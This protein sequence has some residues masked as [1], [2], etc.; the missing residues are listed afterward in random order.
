MN[1]NKIDLANK[2]AELHGSAAMYEL[3]KS[4]FS[5]TADNAN[6]GSLNL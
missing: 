4:P 6:L 5:V 1:A 3:R 2:V